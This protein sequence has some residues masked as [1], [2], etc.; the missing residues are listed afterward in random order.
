MCERPA[1][2]VRFKFLHA[3]CFEM[4]II[5][6]AVLN[7]NIFC[8]LRTFSTLFLITI[9]LTNNSHN[10]QEDVRFEAKDSTLNGWCQL[11]AQRHCH[12][13]VTK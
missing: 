13:V 3:V 1:P 11:V 10:V 6:P 8:C 9:K 5:L 12:W 4:T 2:S 7:A